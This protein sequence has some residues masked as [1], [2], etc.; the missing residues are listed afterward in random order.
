MTELSTGFSNGGSLSHQPASVDED[1]EA[2]RPEPVPLP[3][4]EFKDQLAQVIPHLR[5]FGRSLSGS[6]DLADDLVQE[7]LLKAWA[8]RKRFQAGTNMRAWTFIILRNLFLSQMRRARFKGEWDEITASKM[9]AAPASQ[10]R[11][12]ELGD[13]Q[14]ALLHLP[15]PQREALIL[16]GAGGFA[17][18]EA[19][20]ICGCAV[21][22]IKSRVARGRVALE[23]LLAEGKLTSRREYESDGNS[24]LA[25][26]MSEVDDLSRDRDPRSASHHDDED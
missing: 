6:R 15:Q 7:T 26:I 13:M 20:E 19:A 9:L 14:R 21:G 1:I 5:A 2:V 23:N 25:S 4:N 12:V 16:V 11:H 3:D 18:E 22:T 10:D 17:Y 8:A 24:A